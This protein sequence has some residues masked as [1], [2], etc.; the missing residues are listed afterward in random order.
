MAEIMTTS[1]RYALNIPSP[2]ATGGGFKDWFI[3]EYNRPGFTIELGLGENPLPA[4]SAEEIYLTA[5][6]MLT[7]GTII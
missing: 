4:E 3:E 2:I 1:T 5:R 6:E 7:L